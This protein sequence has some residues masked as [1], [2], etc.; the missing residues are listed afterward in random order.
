MLRHC[1]NILF[2][3]LSVKQAAFLFTVVGTTGFIGLLAGQLPGVIWL[4]LIFSVSAHINYRLRI[5]NIMIGRKF[6]FLYDVMWYHYLLV[7]VYSWDSELSSIYMIAN[8]W[9]LLCNNVRFVRVLFCWSWERDRKLVFV[10]Y[11]HNASSP[12]TYY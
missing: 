10:L 6:M 5:F 11:C 12:L 3:Y 2:E 1:F 4:Y 7:A 8:F 9:S